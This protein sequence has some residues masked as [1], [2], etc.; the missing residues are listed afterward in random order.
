MSTM[1]LD[2][3]QLALL[4]LVAVVTPVICLGGVGLAYRAQERAAAKKQAERSHGV[5]TTSE[6][7]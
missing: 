7:E 2:A 1:S 5:R 3:V 4:I 6:E